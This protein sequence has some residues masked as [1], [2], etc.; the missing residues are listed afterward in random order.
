MKGTRNQVR[1]L[2]TLSMILFLG[3]KKEVKYVYATALTLR[4]SPDING[5]KVDLLPAKA[6]VEI[7][8]TTEKEIK[9]KGKSGKWVKIKYNNKV[10]WVFD[11]FLSEIE[12]IEDYIREH[13]KSIIIMDSEKKIIHEIKH[14]KLKDNISFYNSLTSSFNLPAHHLRNYFQKLAGRSLSFYE[15]NTEYKKIDKNFLKAKGFFS[16]EYV[17]KIKVKTCYFKKHPPSYDDIFGD[18]IIY[19]LNKYDKIRMV[20]D[21]GSAGG[22]N[23]FY[24]FYG[25]IK[26]IVDSQYHPAV[27]TNSLLI[28]F[29]YDKFYLNE[30]KIF[31]GKRQVAR[32]VYEYKDNLPYKLTFE[33]PAWLIQ[34]A[35]PHDYIYSFKEVPA[36]LNTIVRKEIYFNYDFK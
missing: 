32:E 31:I 10:G 28:E 3:C 18:G 12:S 2:L 4:D 13:V 14:F 23:F 35:D 27:E 33:S 25:R 26:M 22:S 16:D 11:A 6:K 34:E 15:N 8:K 20:E 30:V 17:A 1:V 36:N 9:V 24:D 21:F 19:C 5:Q 29:Y 7:L